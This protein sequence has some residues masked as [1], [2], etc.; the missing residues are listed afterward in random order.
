MISYVSKHCNR[1]SSFSLITTTTL[2]HRH[3]CLS[4]IDNKSSIS[5]IT[6]LITGRHKTGTQR[7]ES[8]SKTHALLGHTFICLLADLFI[9]SWLQQI[10]TISPKDG[11]NGKGENEALT[12]IRGAQSLQSFAFIKAHETYPGSIEERKVSCKWGNASQR[13]R[14]LRTS[15]DGDRGPGILGKGNSMKEIQG[16]ANTG[17]KSPKTK[18]ERFPQLSIPHLILEYLNCR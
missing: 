15:I 7:P 1:R 18:E 10:F 5:K 17:Y 8:A 9:P 12:K 6:N 3:I 13:R 14:C 16:S 2:R 11:W 4:F